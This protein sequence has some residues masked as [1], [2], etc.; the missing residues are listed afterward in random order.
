MNGIEALGGG[1]GTKVSGYVESSIAKKCGTCEYIQQS[2]LCSQDTVLGDDEMETDKGTGY[3]VV[4][5]EKGCCDFWE[6]K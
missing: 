3:K 1:S 6:P 4:D 5:P 2:R